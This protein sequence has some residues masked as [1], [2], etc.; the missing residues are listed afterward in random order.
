MRDKIRKNKN[1]NTVIGEILRNGEELVQ[2]KVQEVKKFVKR[3]FACEDLI[4]ELN[5]IESADFKFMMEKQIK[6][7]KHVDE[8][9]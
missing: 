3:S 1:S 2:E 5:L 4:K 6:N 7:V 8:S 9:T